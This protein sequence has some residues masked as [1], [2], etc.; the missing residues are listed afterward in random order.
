MS[1]F[2]GVVPPCPTCMQSAHRKFA[3]WEGEESGDTTVTDYEGRQPKNANA[4]RRV[5]NDE[6]CGTGI[7]CREPGP[8]KPKRA[9]TLK[10]PSEKKLDFNDVEVVIKHLRRA[11]MIGILSKMDIKTT[12]LKLTTMK[13]MKR[14]DL[15]LVCKRLMGEDVECFNDMRAFVQT[16]RG[17]L[18]QAKVDKFKQQEAK[19]KAIPSPSVLC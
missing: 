18:Y 9:K 3:M 5:D 16:K 6:I 10:V 14:D 1:L 13:T 4:R 7:G 12:Y 19:K 11:D 17:K 2:A 15:R 8:M